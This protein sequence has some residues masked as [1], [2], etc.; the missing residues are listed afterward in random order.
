MIGL[1]LAAAFVATIPVAN[2]LIGHVG[3]A[4][5]PN[6]PCVVPVGF[7]LFAPSGVLVVGVALVL[8]DLMQRYWGTGYTLATIAAGTALSFLVSPTI[9]LASAVAFLASEIADLAVY[10]GLAR[11]HGLTVAVLLSGVAGATIDSLVFLLMAFGSLDFMAGQVLG[12]VYAS[13]IF[14]ALAVAYR[15]WR[16]T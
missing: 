9:A 12:K 14:A 8:R 10:T 6:G 2:F 16:W 13:G 11:R 15:Q 4:C 3:T 7:G 1:L 5:L